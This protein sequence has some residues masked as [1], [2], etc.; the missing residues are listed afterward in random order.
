M[1]SNEANFKFLDSLSLKDD[2]YQKGQLFL[3][4]VAIDSSFLELKK[5]ESVEHTGFKKRKGKRKKYYS[6]M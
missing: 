3:K 6:E 2:F 5:G 4:I 1:E